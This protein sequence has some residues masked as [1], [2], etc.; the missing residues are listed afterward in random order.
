MQ[1][2][3]IGK[4]PRSF[5]HMKAGKHSHISKDMSHTLLLYM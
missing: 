5:L 2:K 4:I 1:L 3:M